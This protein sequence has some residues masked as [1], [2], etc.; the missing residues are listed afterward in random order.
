MKKRSSLIEALKGVQLK[1]KHLDG[2]D[3]FCETS[4]GEA[5]GTN[6]NLWKL[7]GEGMKDPDRTYRQ[8]DL[9]IHFKI[10]FPERTIENKKLLRKLKA[11]L[12]PEKLPPLDLSEIPNLRSLESVSSITEEEENEPQMPQGVQCAQQ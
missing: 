4:V 12:P 8:G 7:R 2:R 5:I 11:V 9:Y 3:L 6:K 10:V 1:I